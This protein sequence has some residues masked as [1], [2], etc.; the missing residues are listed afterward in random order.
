MLYVISYDVSD[1]RTRIRAANLLKDYGY[2]VQYSVFVARLDL[3]A[4]N[5]LLARLGQ[6]LNFD[7]DRL[8]CWA[9]CVQDEARTIVDG[10]EEW[11]DQPGAVI[12]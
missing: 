11:F 6:M 10:P 12:L 9:L 3:R 7:T 8:H 2:R 5:R 4:C 1:D